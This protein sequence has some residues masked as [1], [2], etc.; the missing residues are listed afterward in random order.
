MINNGLRSDLLRVIHF[1][2]LMC[3]FF[4][5]APGVFHV[6][7]NEKV[8]V[9]MGASHLHKTVTLYLEHE[10]TNALLSRKKTVVFAAENDVQ[11]VE[12]MVIGS[13]HS[14]FIKIIIQKVLRCLSF[15]IFIDREGKTDKIQTRSQKLAHLHPVGSRELILLSKENNQDSAL[16][17]QGQHLHSD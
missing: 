5:S 6:G 7:V 8:F 17:T 2:P 15:C 9:Q 13:A 14:E 16:K 10:S 11:T 3:R 4:I 1:S 12:L